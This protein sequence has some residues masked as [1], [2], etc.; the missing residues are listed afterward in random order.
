VETQPSRRRSAFVA[1]FLSGIFPG[2]GQ[3]YNGEHGKAALFVL[4][5]LL[6]GFGPLS[7][8]DVDIDPG[9]PGAGLLGVLLAGVP[10]LI[11]AAWSLV[12]AYRAARGARQHLI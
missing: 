10:F 12:D 8:L 11:V 3:L 4:G 7:P 5:A 6:T 9:N 1:V 2:L